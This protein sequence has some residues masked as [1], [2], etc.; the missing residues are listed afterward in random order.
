LNTTIIGTGLSSAIYRHVPVPNLSRGERIPNQQQSKN[1][2]QL[3]IH[4]IV[5]VL[6]G[7]KAIDGQDKKGYHEEKAENDA[8][9]LEWGCD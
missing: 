2:H 3:Y 4:N 6:V 5:D 8:D 1:R 7:P 9:C